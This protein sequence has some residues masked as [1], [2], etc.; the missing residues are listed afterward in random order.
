MKGLTALLAGT[1]FG[2]GLAWSGMSDPANVLAFLTISLDW[3]PALIGTMGGALAV[4]AVGYALVT[5]LERPLY[6]ADFSIPTAREVD[7]RLIAGASVFGVGWGLSGFCPGPALVSFAVLD[8]RALAFVAAF[9]GGV[10]LYEALNRE[11][12]A[13]RD[14]A[15]ADG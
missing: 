7:K 12:V 10:L 3:N 4:T 6:E 2:I 1:L 5:R 11:R 8:V 14:P 13:A 9:L 15:V